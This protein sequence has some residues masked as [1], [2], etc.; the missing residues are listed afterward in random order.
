MLSCRGPAGKSQMWGPKAPEFG[1]TLGN[2][3]WFDR[4]ADFSEL[5]G[6]ADPDVD[7][8][9]SVVRGCVFPEVKRRLLN[10][11]DVT[12]SV[13]STAVVALLDECLLFESAE[14]SA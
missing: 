6:S 4:L 2:F 13:Q 9:P 14:S 12:S 1:A 11:W 5:L 8:V 10:C 3:P 7:L